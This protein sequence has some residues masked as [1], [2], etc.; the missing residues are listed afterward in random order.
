MVNL[1]SD[2]KN[3]WEDREENIQR[4]GELA[5]VITSTGQIFITNI[6]DLDNF[7]AEVLQTLNTPNE[8]L[9]IRIGIP[10][11]SNYPTTLNIEVGEEMEAGIKRIKKMLYQEAVL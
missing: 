11:L 3:N 6:M 8:V 2:L 7:E 10:N 9:I 4:L 1:N 5:Q